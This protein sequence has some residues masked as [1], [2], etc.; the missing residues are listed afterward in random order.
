MQQQAFHGGGAGVDQFPVL[1]GNHFQRRVAA[2]GLRAHRKAVAHKVIQHAARAL[3]GGGG[4]RPA[5]T[6]LQVQR[7]DGHV[8]FGLRR[9]GLGRR[10]QRCVCT[11][12][13]T[14][15]HGHGGQAAVCIAVLQARNALV[16]QHGEVRLHH[17]V[18]GRQVQPDLEEFERVGL[19]GVEQREHFRVLDALARRDPLH[20]APAKAGG[21]AQR[22]GMVDEPLAH[23]RHRFKAPVRVAGKAGHGLAVVHAPAVLAAEVAADLAAFQRH[24][25]RKGAIA[26]G[27][28]VVVVGAEKEGVH[29]GPQRAQGLGLQHGQRGGGSGGGRCHAG[30]LV[31]CA[32][33]NGRP[34]P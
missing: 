10:A 28:G 21:C 11:G 16:P 24:G 29:R 30:L 17:L 31:E 3:A 9:P 25:G 23:Q 26:C 8:G 18:A 4:Q 12:Q 33:P 22:I 5:G 6:G 7:P 19:G 34:I 32:T 15:H 27:V 2:D 1:R 20:I 13:R 14:G